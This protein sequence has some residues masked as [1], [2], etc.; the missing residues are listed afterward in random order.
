MSLANI[1]N[2]PTDDVWHQRRGR[3]KPRCTNAKHQGG[4]DKQTVSFVRRATKPAKIGY[5]EIRS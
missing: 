4:S 3:K 1:Q 5:Q 2:F